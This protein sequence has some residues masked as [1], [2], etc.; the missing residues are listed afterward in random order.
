MNK[1]DVEFF[2]DVICSFCYPMSY[3]MRKIAKE[4]PELN[5]IHKSYALAVDEKIYELEFG[6]RENV[7]DKVLNSWKHANENDDLKRFNIEG[8]K[9]TDFL[10][11]T[12]MKSL[13]ACKVAKMVGSEDLYWDVFDKLQEALFTHNKNIDDDNVIYELIK[14][15]DLD[16]DKWL[17]VYNSKEVIAEVETDLY[18]AKQYNIKSV[19]ALIIDQKYILKG[20]QPYEVILESLTEIYNKKFK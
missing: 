20:A 1:L 7:K 6:S 17:E 2:H 4:M 12:S 5:I 10:F 19:P 3:R 16:F 18:L 15:T 8:M 11:P 13:K 14:E 9:N